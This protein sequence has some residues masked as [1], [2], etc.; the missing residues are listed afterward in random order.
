[1]KSHI[2]RK[3]RCGINR[4]RALGKQ[5]HGGQGRQK[6]SI[7]EGEARGGEEV[8]PGQRAVEQFDL[9]LQRRQ[10]C[11][12]DSAIYRSIGSL[13]KEIRKHV[14]PDQDRIHRGHDDRQP[15][16]GFR[17]GRPGTCRHHRR[18]R[19]EAIEVSHDR[20]GLAQPHLAVTQA[21]NFAQG[22]ECVRLV[23]M[24]THG[25]MIVVDPLF[26]AYHSDRTRKVA[27]RDAVN[28][29]SVL[30]HST[31]LLGC[32]EKGGG[33]VNRQAASPLS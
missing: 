27:L 29:N 16:F 21:G 6:Q 22:M 33:S 11:A 9:L 10:R 15:L 5:T 28:F 12:D 30:A 26:F 32:F 13:R 1:M 4:M 3:I 19:I 23:R 31:A 25:K 24:R 8:F 17:R 7:C 18:L 20:P 14:L 2:A